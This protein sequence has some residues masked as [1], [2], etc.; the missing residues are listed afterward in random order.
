MLVDGPGNVVQPNSEVIKG[1]IV[2]GEVTTEVIG[3]RN[4][5]VEIWSHICSDDKGGLLPGIEFTTGMSGESETD[6]EVWSN[7]CSVDETAGSRSVEVDNE[8]VVSRSEGAVD[9]EA[10]IKVPTGSDAVK[11][12]NVGEWKYGGPGARFEE[13]GPGLHIR[14]TG[15]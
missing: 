11:A 10:C 9:I 8:M 5:D 7:I 14:E 3:R 15:T 12:G 2:P 1:A 4:S 13:D 6:A